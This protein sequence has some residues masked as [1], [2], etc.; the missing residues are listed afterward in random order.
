MPPKAK[1]AADDAWHQGDRVRTALIAVNSAFAQLEAAIDSMQVDAPISVSANMFDA[2]CA[3]AAALPGRIG[4][5]CRPAATPVLPADC[6]GVV[7][8]FALDRRTMA[9][10]GANGCVNE[11][12]EYWPKRD[13]SVTLQLRALRLVSRTWCRLASALVRAIVLDNGQSTRVRH[14][15]TL[16]DT[17]PNARYIGYRSPNCDYSAFVKPIAAALEQNAER[18]HGCSPAPGYPRVY[19]RNSLIDPE[20][21]RVTGKNDTTFKTVHSIA[22]LS[23]ALTNADIVLI[24]AKAYASI[25]YATNPSPLALRTRMIVIVST[26]PELCD[27]LLWLLATADADARKNLCIYSCCRENDYLSEKCKNSGISCMLVEKHRYCIISHARHVVNTVSNVL[28][29]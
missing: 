10:F 5:V 25:T 4:A 17:F 23:D 26:N 19:V 18:R 27:F 2:L 8:E 3:Q 20:I 21:T 1:R 24:N 15:T 12:R 13:A 28:Y 16:A 9:T 6:W 22:K 11:P 29:A 14:P 7:M